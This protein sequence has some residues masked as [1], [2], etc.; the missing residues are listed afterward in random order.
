[1]NLVQQSSVISVV[2]SR[3]KSIRGILSK[4]TP[5]V[6]VPLLFPPCPED[7][8]DLPTHMLRG[9]VCYRSLHYVTF[10]RHGDETWSLFDDARVTVVRARV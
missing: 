7:G 9:L 2:D 8:T 10:F 6:R 5:T 1:M 3:A 4:L